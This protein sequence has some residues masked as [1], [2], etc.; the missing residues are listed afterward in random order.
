MFKAYIMLFSYLMLLSKD[1]LK[2]MD[3]KQK[4]YNHRMS[5]IIKAKRIMPIDNP[6]KTTKIIIKKTTQIALRSRSL[7]NQLNQYNKTI[8]I[9][10]ILIASK[11]PSLMIQPCSR[12][13]SIITILKTH[14]VINKK[15][16]QF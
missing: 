15:D 13:C 7:N 6:N 11:S 3:N 2:R 14:Q 9:K 10:R 16:I 12:M 4:N 5:I 8:E 1:K